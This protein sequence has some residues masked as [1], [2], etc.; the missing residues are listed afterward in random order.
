MV[1]KVCQIWV[2]SPKNYV[3][4]TSWLCGRIHTDCERASTNSSVVGLSRI[5]NETVLVTNVLMRPVTKAP[6]F[7]HAW[8]LDALENVENPSAFHTA[9]RN[10]SSKYVIVTSPVT[11]WN[12]YHQSIVSVWETDHRGVKYSSTYNKL[13]LSAFGVF[14]RYKNNN[15][16]NSVEQAISVNL[17]TTTSRHFN[18]GQTKF[19]KESGILWMI[20]CE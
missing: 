20:W 19:I 8:Y 14:L 11:W 12:T 3:P 6:K 15:K 10:S 18:C 16:S 9:L 2:K 1:F 7:L 4:C 13:I 17:V 5:R